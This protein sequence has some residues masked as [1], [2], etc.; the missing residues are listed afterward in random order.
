MKAVSHMGGV[1]V[2][3][4]QVREIFKNNR[5]KQFLVMRTE[6]KDPFTQEIIYAYGLSKD[7]GKVLYKD[8]GQDH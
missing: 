4:H 7:C 2:P 8:F 5:G 1:R 3:S 6:V